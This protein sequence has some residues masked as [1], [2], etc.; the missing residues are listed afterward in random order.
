MTNNM[1]QNNICYNCLKPFCEECADRDLEERNEVLNF[2]DC[3]KKDYCQ[4]CLV[5]EHCSNDC[6][7][8]VCTGCKKSCEDCDSVYCEDCLKTCPGCNKS[9]CPD[10]TP[11]RICDGDACHDSIYCAECLDA[12]G[13]IGISYCSECRCLYCFGCRADKV[14]KDGVDACRGCS[15]DITPLLLE[16]NS[17]LRKENE[18]MAKENEELTEKVKHMSL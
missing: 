7:D 17:K 13:R 8:W 10:C 3:C 12:N 2:C 6:G 5:I 15:A 14:K 9:R 1:L 4:N 18:K 16:E 11:L